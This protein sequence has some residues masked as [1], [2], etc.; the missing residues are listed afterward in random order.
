MK[1]E[2]HHGVLL[3]LMSRHPWNLLSRTKVDALEGRKAEKM[4]D[5]CSFPF[6]PISD[7]RIHVTLN[8]LKSNFFGG[9]WVTQTHLE[10]EQKLPFH[11]NHTLVCIDFFLERLAL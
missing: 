5:K 1:D 7:V 4:A 8:L 11:K 9:V 3:L 6:F 10:S 2:R